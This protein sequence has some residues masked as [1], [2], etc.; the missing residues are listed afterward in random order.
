MNQVGRVSEL[1]LHAA[2]ANNT[3][4]ISHLLSSILHWNLL[5]SGHVI[6]TDL[7]HN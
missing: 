1:Y 7:N 5:S 2:S 6:A 4:G 3:C